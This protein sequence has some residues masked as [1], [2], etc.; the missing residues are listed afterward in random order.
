MVF[1]FG[2]PGVSHFGEPGGRT[3]RSNPMS[4]AALPPDSPG[5]W[6]LARERDPAKSGA[7]LSGDVTH[8][9]TPPEPR[10]ALPRGAADPFHH[11]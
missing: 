7:R 2:E 4:L 11:E 8:P 10:A 1:R 3:T 9:S 5:D 6:L